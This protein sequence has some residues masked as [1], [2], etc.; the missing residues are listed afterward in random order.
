[1]GKRTA[2]I[3]AANDA[4]SDGRHRSP[5]TPGMTRAVGDL[6]AGR[7]S[8]FRPLRLLAELLTILLALD[9]VL[10]AASF[11]A[12]KLDHDDTSRLLAADHGP[13]A[14]PAGAAVWATMIVFVVWFHRARVNAE[15]SGWLQRRAR[16]WT[17]WGWIV[18]IADLFVPF[19]LMGDIW[20]A[21]LPPERR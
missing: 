14:I 12:F 15:R 18:P 19:Q 6:G 2:L 21:G 4:D 20:R 5:Y 13:V 3:T 17:F 7:T 1:V 16:A 9:I 11:L 10:G 8:E